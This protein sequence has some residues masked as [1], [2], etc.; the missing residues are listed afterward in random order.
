ML[1]VCKLLHAIQH[2][3]MS[4][5]NIT[6]TP[7]TKRKISIANTRDHTELYNRLEEYINN[8]QPND[9]PLIVS[10]S[11][12]AGISEQ[13][14]LNYELRTTEESRIRELLGKIRMLQKDYLIKNGLSNKINSPLTMRL[15]SAEHNLNEKPQQLTQNNTFNISPEL[16][17]EAIELSRKK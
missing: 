15:L 6:T 12:Y 1:H 9:V 17:A 5:R 14:L 2:T 11:L 4:Y 13:A 16:L 3:Y 8:L 7:E 10:A